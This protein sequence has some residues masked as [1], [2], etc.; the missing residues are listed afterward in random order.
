MYTKKLPHISNKSKVNLMNFK[1]YFSL[2][3][4]VMFVVNK[5]APKQST[6]LRCNDASTN[7]HWFFVTN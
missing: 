7:M 2:L 4:S 6:L 3:Q 5:D 1:F